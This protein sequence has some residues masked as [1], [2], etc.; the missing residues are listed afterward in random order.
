MNGAPALLE[1]IFTAGERPHPTGQKCEI[2]L[3][4]LTRIYYSTVQTCCMRAVR[5]HVAFSSSVTQSSRFLVHSLRTVSRRRS[6]CSICSLPVR[7]HATATSK[8]PWHPPRPPIAR[9]RRP[10]RGMNRTKPRSRLGE[11]PDNVVGLRPQHKEAFV[12]IGGP[13]GGQRAHR[14]VLPIRGLPRVAAHHDL[15]R[16]DG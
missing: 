9:P 16:L 7:Q 5:C 10:Q 3:Q 15:L 11:D 12:E 8:A 2:Q 1:S 13:S 4:L 6:K 14:L